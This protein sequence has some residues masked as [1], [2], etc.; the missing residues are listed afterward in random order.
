M[1]AGDLRHRL[2]IQKPDKVKDPL[3]GELV[4]GWI[5][6]TTVWGSVEDL[7]G[8]EF[9]AAQQ[10]NA[11]ITTQ[12]IIRYQKG[13]KAIMRIVCDDRILELAAP[14]MDPDGRRRELH[15]L[16]KGVS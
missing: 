2:T 16:C 8:K 13:I 15:L 5:D 12:V 4:D 3:S 9:F 10:V 14:P 11:E 6:V 1:R 7:A